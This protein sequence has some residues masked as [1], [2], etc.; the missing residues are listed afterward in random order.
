MLDRG[1]S[2]RGE[3][4]LALSQVLRRR[5]KGRRIRAA[6]STNV[7]VKLRCV[8][9]AVNAV[10]VVIEVYAKM[11]FQILLPRLCAP[12]LIFSLAVGW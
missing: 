5:Q 11:I 6:G 10:P 4:A 7:L 3:G 9:T 8:T 12:L 1:F 2:R